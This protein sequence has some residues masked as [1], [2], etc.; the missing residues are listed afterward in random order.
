MQDK[1]IDGQINKRKERERDG[2]QREG[3]KNKQIEEKKE[4]DREV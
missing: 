2:R 3:K 4:G 1:G